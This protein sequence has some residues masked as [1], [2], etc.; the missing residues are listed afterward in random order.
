MRVRLSPL[1][2]GRSSLR[3]RFSAAFQSRSFA[4]PSRPSVLRLLICFSLARGDS[5]HIVVR[6][7]DGTSLWHTKVLCDGSGSPVWTPLSGAT[8]SKPTLTAS[9]G[10]GKLHLAVRGLDNGTWFREYAS[11]WGSWVGVPTGASCDG[12]A[13][14]VV[15]NKL[16]FVVR[17]MD[18]NTLWHGYVDLSTDTFTG[19]DPLSG[20]TP[21]A[22]TLTT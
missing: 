8:P 1:W 9:Q 21:S 17:G 2:T 6:G 11:S 15:E 12:P 20:S 7:M 18:G 16:H 13:A 10:T 22:L 19:W 14:A 4:G 3:N 5:L